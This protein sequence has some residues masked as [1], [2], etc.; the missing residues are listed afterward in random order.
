MVVVVVVVVVVVWWRVGGG[1]V[2]WIDRASAAYP[3][4]LMISMPIAEHF[5]AVA[6]SASLS[7][8]L[9]VGKA[10]VLDVWQTY[11][12]RARR[13]ADVWQTYDRRMAHV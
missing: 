7:M 4:V 12:T 11:G 5:G 1:L 8:F 10:H 13:M 6:Q 3:V 2:G 9:C